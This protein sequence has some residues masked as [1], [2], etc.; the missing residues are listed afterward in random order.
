M[1]ERSGVRGYVASRPFAGDWAPQH[2]Q[3][4]VIRDYCQRHG[5]RYLLSAV[6]YTMQDCFMMLEQVLGE[7]DGL[8]GIVFY[9]IFM[10]PTR[11]DHRHDIYTRILEKGATLHAAVENLNISR[12][13]DMDRTEDLWMARQTLPLCPQS[14]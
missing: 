12:R 9:S 8:E 7:L 14:L 6:E 4:I 1:I 13:E 2:V 5:L 10:L 11:R 3:N